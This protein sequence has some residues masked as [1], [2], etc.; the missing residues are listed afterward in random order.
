MGE[1]TR[2]NI[3]VKLGLIYSRRAN[4]PTSSFLAVAMQMIAVVLGGNIGREAF[5]RELF[6]AGGLILMAVGLVLRGGAAKPARLSPG[7]EVA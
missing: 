5:A 2:E 4:K 7:E 1:K 6:L 3:I